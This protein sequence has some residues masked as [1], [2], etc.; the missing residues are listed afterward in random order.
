MGNNLI[1][2]H[3][4]NLWPFLSVIYCTKKD[5]LMVTM[6]ELQAKAKN[7]YLVLKLVNARW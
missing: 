5:I 6:K 4:Q 7:L 2:L 3:S 1:Q